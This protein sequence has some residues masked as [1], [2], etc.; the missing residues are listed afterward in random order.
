M[1]SYEIECIEILSRIKDKGKNSNNNNKSKFSINNIINKNTCSV[2]KGVATITIKTVNHKKMYCS[3]C[4]I[5]NTDGSTIDII[6]DELNTLKK[7]IKLP[8]PP[9]YVNILK[10]N[11]CI[12]DFPKFIKSIPDI[13]IIEWKYSNDYRNMFWDFGLFF[14]PGR[15][16]GLEKVGILTTALLNQLYPLSQLFPSSPIHPPRTQPQPQLSP[17]IPHNRQD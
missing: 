15:V 10:D 4:D 9:Q 17:P 6:N 16:G 7:L 5:T 1:N 14:K 2:C 3:S 12:F 13:S 11:V 8:E